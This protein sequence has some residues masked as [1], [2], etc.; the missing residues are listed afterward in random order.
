METKTFLK[1]P[2]D[3]NFTAIAK[4]LLSRH[5]GFGAIN[6]TYDFS[7]EIGNC[8]VRR[9]GFER[10]EPTFCHGQYSSFHKAIT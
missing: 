9:L 3:W 8:A 10:T 4:H 6:N 2:K 5:P 7:R 1:V